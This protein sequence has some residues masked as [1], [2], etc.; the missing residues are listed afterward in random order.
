MLFRNL[1]AMDV[2]E[3]IRAD[4][5]DAVAIFVRMRQDRA[6]R[7]SDEELGEAESCMSRSSGHCMVTG[8]SSEWEHEHLEQQ[9]GTHRDREA[10]LSPITPYDLFTT[11]FT[12]W[13]GPEL[14]TP[15]THANRLRAGPRRESDSQT[16]RAYS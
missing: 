13:N 16:A 4:P 9:P 7:L 5:L 15:R 3:C 8:S 11:P 2:E 6:G 12:P 1:M 10:I 14:H